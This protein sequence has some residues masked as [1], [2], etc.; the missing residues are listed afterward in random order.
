[1]K[2]PVPEENK[3]FFFALG[4]KNLIFYT[5]A[6]NIHLVDRLPKGTFSFYFPNKMYARQV[7]FSSASLFIQYSILKILFV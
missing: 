1:V 7:A 2:V 6:K 5:L 3:I 4:E